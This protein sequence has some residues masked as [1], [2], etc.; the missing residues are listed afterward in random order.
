MNE[1]YNKL[2]E[3][4]GEDPQEFQ[5]VVN[6]DNP[7]GIGITCEELWDFLEFSINEDYLNKEINSS[8]LITNGNV[9]TTLKIIHDLA[10]KTGNFI[11]YINE[12]NVS[13]N[14]YFM[15]MANKI[16][17]KLGLNV[18]IRADL[19]RNYNKYLD[20]SVTLIGSESFMREAKKDFSNAN[21]III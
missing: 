15:K 21:V 20:Q 16:Y 17:E 14:Y 5:T 2:L 18:Q 6:A 4:I 9:Y 1:I 12:N 7:A 19:S 10:F 3:I 8:I 11:I 13:T